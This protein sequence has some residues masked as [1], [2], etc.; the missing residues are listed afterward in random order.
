MYKDKCTCWFF[1]YKTRLNV[2]H[3]TNKAKKL[4]V[5][6]FFFCNSANAPKNKNSSLSQVIELASRPFCHTF[7]LKAAPG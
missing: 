2:R 5:P 4:I 7:R 1:V 3:G 6:P